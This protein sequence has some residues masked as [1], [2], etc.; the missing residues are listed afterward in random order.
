MIGQHLRYFGIQTSKVP[1]LPCQNPRL[2]FKVADETRRLSNS[3]AWFFFQRHVYGLRGD[4]FFEQ[5]ITDS[6][7]G[8]RR[9][10]P[11]CLRHCRR[12]NDHTRTI[13]NDA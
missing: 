7:L 3:S 5:A 10:R 6:P 8:G 2:I 4:H 1:D 11:C 13:I 12:E 9:I